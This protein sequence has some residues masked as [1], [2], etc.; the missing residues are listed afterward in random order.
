[1]TEYLCYAW[2]GDASRLLEQQAGAWQRR[3]L[4]TMT[5]A[6]LRQ[7]AGQGLELD[8]SSY[9][10]FRDVTA[11]LWSQLAAVTAADVD[12][13]ADNFLRRTYAALTARLAGGND[14]EWAAINAH[15]IGYYLAILRNPEEPT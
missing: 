2:S 1:M 4:Q 12:G 15:R 10:R 11:W 7:L 13:V 8:T 6:Q 3:K 14:I 9:H 5:V